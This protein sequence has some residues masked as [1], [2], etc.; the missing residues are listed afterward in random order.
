MTKEALKQ[1]IQDLGYDTPARQ[2]VEATL[3]RLEAQG[4]AIYWACIPKS[5]YTQQWEV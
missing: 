3:R 2:K 1:E 5:L 4:V